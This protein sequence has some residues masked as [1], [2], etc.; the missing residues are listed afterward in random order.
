MLAAKRLP[1]QPIN[2]MAAYQKQLDQQGYLP[3]AA[4]ASAL[5]RLQNLATALQADTATPPKG[6]YLHGPVGR[7]K[8]WLMELFHNAVTMPKRRVHFHAFM[9]ELHTRLH[10]TT[11]RPGQDLMQVVAAQIANE[12][13]LLCFDEFYITNIA[14]AMLLGRLFQALFAQ[15]VVIVATSNWAPEDLF[16]GGMNR[17]RFMPFI[18]QIEKMM[19]VVSI[20]A[21]RDYRL[22]G[23]QGDAGSL[24]PY[25]VVAEGKVSAAPQLQVL[26][27]EFAVGVETTLPPDLPCKKREGRAAWFMFADLCDKS[28]GREQYLDLMRA[29]DT[30]VIEGVPVFTPAEADSALRFVTL[31]DICYEHKRRMVVS[32]A[33]A[34]HRLCPQGDAA[35]PFK[36]TA[37]R[38]MQLCDERTPKKP[39]RAMVTAKSV[40]VPKAH[41]RKS[42]ASGKRARRKTVGKAT[43]RAA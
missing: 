40:K 16:Q 42:V 6:L 1:P 4:Q 29:C 9:Q 38:L 25:Y 26:F 22:R 10:T 32:A 5:V 3:D 23:R 19:D 24:P 36:R 2:L 20:G 15:G 41:T 17:D 13:S 34:P 27:D 30:V 18:R 8:S 21:G 37:S 28:Y 11:T 31:V 39:R 7:G 33:A 14:D 12:A 35:E 43:G